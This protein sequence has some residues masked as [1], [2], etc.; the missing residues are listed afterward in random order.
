M[1]FSSTKNISAKKRNRKVFRADLGKSGRVHLPQF[2]AF[3]S[4]G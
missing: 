2:S 4:Q 1:H 3:L